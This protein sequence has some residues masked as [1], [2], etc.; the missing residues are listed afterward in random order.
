MYND[1]YIT[2]LIMY[3]D[4]YITILIILYI[5]NSKKKNIDSSFKKNPTI[6]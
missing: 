4:Y 3:N 1:Y 5:V 6:I 2:I